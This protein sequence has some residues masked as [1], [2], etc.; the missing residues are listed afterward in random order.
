MKAPAEVSAKRDLL[1]A[2]VSV[3]QPWQRSQI[4]ALAVTQSPHEQA[5]SLQL[6][7]ALA[8]ADS[9]LKYCGYSHA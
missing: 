6:R 3:N 4:A 9:S 7:R 5:W 8:T 2:I 1:A